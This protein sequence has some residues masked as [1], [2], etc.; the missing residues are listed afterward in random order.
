MARQSPYPFTVQSR[1]P[2]FDKYVSW[3]VFY[4]SYDPPIVCVDKAKIYLTKELY[5]IDPEELKYKRKINF[6]V[7]IFEFRIYKKIVLAKLFLNSVWRSESLLYDL[8]FDYK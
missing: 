5:L 6:L 1:F 8:E 4:D 3:E 7:V 2:V